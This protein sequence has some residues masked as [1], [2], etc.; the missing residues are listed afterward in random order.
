MATMDGSVLHSFSLQII[1]LTPQLLGD[2]TQTLSRVT[3][4]FIVILKGHGL[5]CIERFAVIAFDHN[6][7]KLLQIKSDNQG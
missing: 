3:V 6:A 7:V 5:D 4:A 2:G 1:L